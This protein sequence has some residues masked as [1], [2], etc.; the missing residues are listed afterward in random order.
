[1]TTPTLKELREKWDRYDARLSA[2]DGDGD[3]S[4][5]GASFIIARSGVTDVRALLD[6]CTAAEAARDAATAAI[7]RV[8][9]LHYATVDGS[10]TV[11]YCE[12][13]GVRDDFTEAGYPCPTIAALDAPVDSEGES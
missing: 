11:H 12:E 1:M 5:V 4:L 7:E 2:G 9:K 13:C 6:R 10:G 8:R 3:G